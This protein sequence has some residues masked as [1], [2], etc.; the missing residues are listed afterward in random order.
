MIDVKRNPRFLRKQKYCRGQTNNLE[1]KGTKGDKYNKVLCYIII[2]SN[3]S[4]M[5]FG[6]SITKTPSNQIIIS[7]K[8]KL[9]L[10]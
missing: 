5:C 8:S 2:Y 10:L 1:N 6:L 7:Y 9:F 3:S 4:A